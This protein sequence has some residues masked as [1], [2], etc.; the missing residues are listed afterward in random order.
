MRAQ[1]ESMKFKLK[2]CLYEDY[3]KKKPS[4]EI[5]AMVHTLVQQELAKWHDKPKKKKDMKSDDN[6]F[7]ILGVNELMKE[8]LDN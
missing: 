2:K 8:S 4:A 3:T 7:P 1:Y 5:N 6:L